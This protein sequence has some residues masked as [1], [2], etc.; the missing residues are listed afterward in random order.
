MQVT[1][2]DKI[3]YITTINVI[4]EIGIFLGNKE[5]EN[6][7]I[8]LKPEADKFQVPSDINNI[9]HMDYDIDLVDKEIDETLLTSLCADIKDKIEASTPKDTKEVVLD[10]PK[11]EVYLPKPCLSDIETSILKIIYENILSKKY[12]LICYNQLIDLNERYE[13]TEK[14]KI[15]LSKLERE[16]IIEMIQN[17]CSGNQSCKYIAINDEWIDFIDNLFL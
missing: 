14:L 2:N 10:T 4:L 3:S 11:E 5:S 7:L 12:P 8:L 9:I 15:I 6:Q 17:D 16:N 1:H 13:I